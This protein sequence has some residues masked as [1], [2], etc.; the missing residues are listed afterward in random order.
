MPCRGSGDVCNPYAELQYGVRVSSN[1][2][3]EQR[4]LASLLEDIPIAPFETKSGIAYGTIRL[5]TR[6]RKAEQLDKLI[7]AHAVSL[8]VVLVTNNEKDFAKY[9][10]LRIE[11]WLESYASTSNKT[12]FGFFLN[13]PISVLNNLAFAFLAALLLTTISLLV[14]LHRTKQ[15]DAD[16][17]SLRLRD[18]HQIRIPRWGGVGIFIGWLA[19]CYFWLLPV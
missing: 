18:Q 3:Q 12:D 15:N 8:G 7:A 11:N 5:A 2:E 17:T 4:S 9:P 19:S 10:G 6:E 13:N 16:K 14:L 1:P